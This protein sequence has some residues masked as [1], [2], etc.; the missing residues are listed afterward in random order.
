MA[1][2]GEPPPA[3]DDND[4]G[5]DPDYNDEFDDMF[6][7][8]RQRQQASTTTTTT[9]QNDTD[10]GT[11][12]VP[13]HPPPA[14][15]KTKTRVHVTRRASNPTIKAQK[16]SSLGGSVTPNDTPTTSTSPKQKESALSTNRPAAF[17]WGG[18]EQVASL[19]ATNQALLT[20]VDALE[21]ELAQARA[22]A[23][24]GDDPE[25]LFSPSA[26][27]SA[28]VSAL[29]KRN[30][31]LTASL[32]AE[33]A[34]AKSA[35]KEAADMKKRI[36]ELESKLSRAM[37]AEKRAQHKLA[38]ATGGSNKTRAATAAVMA[39]AEADTRQGDVTGHAMTASTRHNGADGPAS[40]EAAGGGPEHATTSKVREYRRECQ[41]LR[42]ELQRATAALSKEVGTDVVVAR[43]L[44]GEPGWQG[45]AEEIARLKAEIHKLKTDGAGSGGRRQ[46]TVTSSAEERSTQA[47]RSLEQQRHKALEASARERDA[48]VEAAADL[49]SKADGLKARNRALAR[50]LKAAKERAAAAESETES[51]RKKV[52]EL[53][54][55]TRDSGVF[56][57]QSAPHNAAATKRDD[58]DM[59]RLIDKVQAQAATIEHLEQRLQSALQ[60]A[61]QGRPLSGSKV[62]T[63][64][65]A[66]HGSGG[67]RVDAELLRR[68]EELDALVTAGDLER[69]QLKQLAASRQARVST[70]E[71][72]LAAT[73]AELRTEKAW[74]RTLKA[75]VSRLSQQVEGHIAPLPPGE[76][77]RLE[78]ENKLV[79]QTDE[80]A[81]LRSTLRDAL[82]A[83]EEQIALLHD[84]LESTKRVF[85]DGL[86]S[87]KAR[88]GG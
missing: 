2:L 64:G 7:T 63:P 44:A 68:A 47:I 31:D 9:T 83:K 18:F 74:V 27:A 48:A 15:K 35:G 66:N 87:Y 86:R 76:R 12:S 1:D 71:R 32:N 55:V 34:R 77:T 58:A 85:S 22:V 24:T 4:L 19:Q 3:F 28:K 75:D 13:A 8:H 59:R 21:A 62:I 84:L 38:L 81:A 6:L 14:S 54:E 67:P 43:V 11:A 36:D 39:A 72:T 25:A 40:P 79:I 53:M 50:E 23:S 49:K 57:R 61:R 5:N 17:D 46:R 80:N 73:Q 16:S 33:K 30:R 60:L 10:G 29:S 82:A 51:E 56:R 65:A 42:R 26:S 69:T 37:A 78:L 88:L 45:R 41:E 52:R 70:L 20:Q